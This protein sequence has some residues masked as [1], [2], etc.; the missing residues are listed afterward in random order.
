MKITALSIGSLGDV[1]P[2]ILLGKELTKKG[3]DFSIAA[4]PDFQPEIEAAGLTYKLIEGDVRNMMRILLSERKSSKKSAGIEGLKSVLAAHPDVYDN[5]NNAVIGNDLIIYM[6]FGAIAYHFAEKYNIPCIRTFVFPSDPTKQYAVLNPKLP[7]N[8]I[9]CKI[10][11]KTADLCMNLGSI[12][13][14]NLWRKKLGLKKWH[15]WSSYKKMNGKPILTLYQYSE[16]LAPRDPKW[17]SHIHI[18]G[19]WLD[20]SDHDY[21]PSAELTDFLKNG[22]APIFI[23]FGSMVYS[24]MP[25]LQQKILAALEKSGERAILASSWSKFETAQKNS[26]IFYIDYVP[27]NWLFK[28]VKAVVHHG[29]SGTTHLGLKYG[30]P[31]FVMA[32]GADQYYWGLQVHTLGVGPKP[33]SIQSDDFTIDS[34]AEKFSDL[35]RSQYIKSAEKI[36]KQLLKE[37]GL[38][39]ACEIIEKIYTIIYRS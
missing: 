38:R 19:P 33:V 4:F 36:S 37:N 9:K 26:N 17:K 7:R 29:G 30:K 11:Y 15:K 3:H 21:I 10:F 39:T 8:S 14:V 6:Q 28:H 13:H 34:L 31:T 25:E 27:Y 24:K 20:D 12:E 35:S 32:F 23:G 18:T 22:S 5:I 2:F 16:V 1:Q